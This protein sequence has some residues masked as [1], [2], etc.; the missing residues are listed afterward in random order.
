MPKYPALQVRMEPDQDVFDRRQVGEETDVLIGTGDAR[1]RTI[2]SGR[3]PTRLCPFRKISPFLPVKTRHTQLK[4]VVLLPLFG[5][6][7]LWMLLL[8]D[9]HIQFVHGDESAEMFCRTL[10]CQDRH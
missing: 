1:R 3:R 2:W 9:V 4:K 5:P 10:G 6:I 7:T 8:S